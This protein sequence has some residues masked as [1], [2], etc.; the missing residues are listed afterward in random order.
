MQTPEANRGIRSCRSANASY[1]L[2]NL[3]DFC[4][5]IGCRCGN[6]IFWPFKLHLPTLLSIWVTDCMK[7]FTPNTRACSNT[8][9]RKLN[10]FPQRASKHMCRHGHRN[11]CHDHH[12]RQT[13]E[14]HK[15]CWREVCSRGYVI[16]ASLYNAKTGTAETQNK[17]T[18]ILG[19]ARR[20]AAQL[21]AETGE[22]NHPA[23][24]V[25]V[26]CHSDG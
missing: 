7:L 12:Q 5:V 3:F 24:L 18:R 22:A 20:I 14:C 16:P 13:C 26:L 10:C 6:L 9:G 2:R 21:A 25:D 1:G 4:W 15:S 8:E 11:S 23:P 17:T 19:S